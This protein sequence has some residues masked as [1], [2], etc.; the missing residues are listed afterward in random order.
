[1]QSRKSATLSQLCAKL[2]RVQWSAGCHDRFLQNLSD[3]FETLIKHN[4]EKI[5]IC[6]SFVS[7]R[8]VFSSQ[9]QQ[10]SGL[11]ETHPK[12]LVNSETLACYRYRDANKLSAPFKTSIFQQRCGCFAAIPSDRRHKI[13]EETADDLFPPIIF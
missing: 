2:R 3:T 1:M 12:S 11:M 7:M 10:Y 13:S 8:R 6:G 9:F 4:C 5:V